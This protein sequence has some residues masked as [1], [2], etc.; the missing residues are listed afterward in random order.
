M[1]TCLSLS[2]FDFDSLMSFIMSSASYSKSV[3]NLEMLAAAVKNLLSLLIAS[4]FNLSISFIFS[5][6]VNLNFISSSWQFSLLKNLFSKVQ[7]FNSNFK[8]SK[9]S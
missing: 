3:N 6:T 9:I 2:D 7:Y 5:F 1:I 8:S 4:S